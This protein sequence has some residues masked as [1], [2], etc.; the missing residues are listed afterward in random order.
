MLGETPGIPEK[1]KKPGILV[2]VVVCALC[3]T[4]WGPGEKKQP[5]QRING[6]G[7]LVHLKC[8]QERA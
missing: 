7:H 2:N 3:R 8:W 6:Q 1:P 4:K 5:L